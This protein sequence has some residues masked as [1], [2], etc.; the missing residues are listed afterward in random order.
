MITPVFA[1]TSTERILPKLALDFTTASLDARITFARTGNT[2]T[3]IDNTG[4]IVAVNANVPRFDYNPSTLS[5]LGLL[6]EESR[7]NVLL[8]SLIDGTNLSTQT[9]SVTAAA[10]TLSF[11]GTGTIVLSGTHSATVAG[12]GAYP[13]RTTYTFTPTAGNLTLT[14]TGTVQYAQLELGTFATSFIPTAGTAVTRNI[15]SATMTGTN[16]S[17]WFNATQ[18]GFYA[19]YDTA[20]TAANNGILSASGGNNGERIQLSHLTGAR[21][22]VVTTLG[23]TQTSLSGGTLGSVSA[24]TVAGMT[25]AYQTNSF[26]AAVNGGTVATAS[27]GNIPTVNT[28]YI[29]SDGAGTNLL[30]GH[31][32]K[33]SY[34]PQR[35]TNAESQAFSK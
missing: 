12:T 16:F 32:A 2:A 22:Y 25:C 4:K 30:N 9:V 23:V 5:C 31:I 35:I 13:S 28:L 3:V 26:V 33:I 19:K 10:R 34:W 8:N 7:I 20:S 11:Y 6:I 17:S 15:D 29:G 1:P 24:N 21:R 18:G 27:S 14:V